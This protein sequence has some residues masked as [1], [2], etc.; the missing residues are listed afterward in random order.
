MAG[1]STAGPGHRSVAELGFVNDP[2]QARVLS[3]ALGS[4]MSAVLVAG[5]EEQL[6]LSDQGVCAMSRSGL[7][8]FKMK[9]SGGDR[10]GECDGLGDRLGEGL[11]LGDRL[12]EGL[13]LGSALSEC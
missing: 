11:A 7:L 2:Q 10:L 9:D 6:K 4:K 8:P 5:K 3:W 13:A 12:G 1:C